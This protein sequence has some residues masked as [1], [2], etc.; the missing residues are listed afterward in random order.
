MDGFFK[1]RLDLE[2][3]ENL[4]SRIDEIKIEDDGKKAGKAVAYTTVDVDEAFLIIVEYLHI[5][6]AK[7]LENIE[8]LCE[9][10]KQVWFNNNEFSDICFKIGLGED[11]VVSDYFGIYQENGLISLDLVEW[12]VIDYSLI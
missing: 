3:F 11:D 5:L 6:K 1:T 8:I 2:D 12:F 10:G 9:I 7:A 4:I